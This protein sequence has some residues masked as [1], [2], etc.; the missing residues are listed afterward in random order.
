MPAPYEQ[1]SFMRIQRAVD[2]LQD[3][4]NIPA[5]LKFLGRTPLVPAL[6]GEIMAR[7]IARG[8]IADLVADDGVAAVYNLGK[9]QTY[10]SEPANIKVGS[11]LTQAEINEIN[12]VDKSEDGGL[13]DELLVR[14]VDFLLR[15][16]YERM[17]SLC[18]AMA[19][20]TF[21]YNRLGFILTGVTWGMPADLKITVAIPWEANPTTATPV[22]DIGTAQL[23]AKT[24]YGIDYNRVTMSTAA[25]RRMIATTEFQNKSKLY[26][27]IGFTQQNFQMTNLDQQR[28]FASS[29][30]GM[31]IEFY[32]SR[33]WSMTPAGVLSSFPFWPLNKV[34]LSATSS[35]NNPM[36]QDFANGI[37]TESRVLNLFGGGANT[38]AVGGIIGSLSGARRGPIGY[39]TLESLNPPNLTMW[40]VARGWPRKH[41]LQA[42]AILDVGAITDPISVTEPF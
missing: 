2:A 8:Q 37:T 32:D 39:A 12:R 40:S 30:L 35:D 7:F 9:F 17:E 20:D 31:E 34:C 18:I 41:M 6:D 15:G 5:D 13:V 33:Y 28:A 29:V 25:F 22:D 4:R 21:S 24:R 14:R 1:L 42:N 19:L 36:V 27:P 3:Q 23:V 11:N 38:P 16:V 26:L 10:A